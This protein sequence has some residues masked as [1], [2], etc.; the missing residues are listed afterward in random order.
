MRTD[1]YQHASVSVKT[2][3]RIVEQMKEKGENATDSRIEKWEKDVKILRKDVLNWSELREENGWTKVAD[4]ARAM[5][6]VDMN[7]TF[8]GAWGTQ[9]TPDEEVAPDEV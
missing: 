9:R 4:Y 7:W 2:Y 5:T 3:H 8:E 1:W 6:V